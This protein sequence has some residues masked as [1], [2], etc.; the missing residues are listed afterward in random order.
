M[1]IKKIFFSFLLMI[2]LSVFSQKIPNGFVYLSDVDASIQKELRYF[3]NNN[4]I[5]KKIDGYY[6]DCVIVSTETADTL[7]KLHTI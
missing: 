1:I 4:F 5:G 3:S 6:N 2:C 7:H